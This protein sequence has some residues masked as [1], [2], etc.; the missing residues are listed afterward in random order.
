MLNC[1][2]LSTV[3]SQHLEECGKRFEEAETLDLQ[4]NV[5]LR[6]GIRYLLSVK[7][8][9][10]FFIQ[11][12]FT[13]P[14]PNSPTVPVTTNFEAI[15]RNNTSHKHYYSISFMHHQGRKVGNTLEKWG[16]PSKSR[17]FSRSLNSINLNSKI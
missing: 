16:I 1:L 8:S 7:V 5:G 10:D 9:G 4:K 11:F 3:Q 12:S 15:S 2:S 6:I 14:Q 17:D 13:L